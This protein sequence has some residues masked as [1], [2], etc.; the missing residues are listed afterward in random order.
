MQAGLADF[1][2]E[3]RVG[4]AQRGKP[5]RRHLAQNP[6]GQSHQRE[7]LAQ[8]E[9]AVQPQHSGDLAHLVAEEQRQRFEHRHAAILPR[10]VVR[11]AQKI[12]VI[13]AHHQRLRAGDGLRL[14]DHL[15][16]QAGN[17]HRA[18]FA[19]RLPAAK[20]GP[21][22]LRA[23]DHAQ[24]NPEL[25]VNRP[26]SG[27]IARAHQPRFDVD[28]RHPLAERLMRQHRGH[29]GIHAAAHAAN[30]E[31]AFN[32]GL[33]QRAP[34]F[35]QRRVHREPRRAAADV[36]RKVFEDGRAVRVV[37]LQLKLN[38]EKRPFAVFK[39]DGA[40]ARARRHLHVGRQHQRHGLLN[41]AF[42]A[43]HAV[44]QLA[45]RVLNV[46]FFLADG[47]ARTR[48]AHRRNQHVRGVPQRQHGDIQLQNLRVEHARR[49]LRLAAEHE[50]ARRDFRDLFRR[51]HAADDFAENPLAAK[52]FRRLDGK[53]IRVIE[54]EDHVVHASFPPTGRALMCPIPKEAA[55]RLG[56]T[57]SSV[58]K[59]I[60][61]ARE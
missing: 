33:R 45:F 49:A 26:Y 9:L 19:H 18:L 30:R 40:A 35:G 59:G 17:D 55:P 27:A 48:A 11:A 54:N 32:R 41:V 36:A 5:L 14:P 38:A 43:L 29:H 7:G 44:K 12:A 25:L 53:L 23:V 46:R 50:P 21:H 1:L 42:A 34:R 47:R 52:P 6:R 3:N 8:Q 16:V 31:S 2:A 13:R 15:L 22:V 28:R 10:R 58:T 24:R 4:R 57:A 39:G 61:S 60:R 37:A 51:R 20:A 56:E